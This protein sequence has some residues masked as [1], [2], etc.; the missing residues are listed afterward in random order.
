[1]TVDDDIGH[2]LLRV[3]EAVDGVERAESETLNPEDRIALGRAREALRVAQR[4]LVK[5]LERG[6]A[7]D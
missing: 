6:R 7:Q 5:L 4:E 2:A 3:A 1:M